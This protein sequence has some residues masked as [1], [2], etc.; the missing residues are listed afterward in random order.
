MQLVLLPGMDGTGELLAPFLAEL[1]ADLKPV[2]VRY[3][4][5]QALG[6]DELEP[7]VD[8]AL[9]DAGP[10]VLLAESYSGPL[11]IRLAARGN[12][13]LVAAVVVGSF[14]RCPVGHWFSW[15]GRLLGPLCVRL[16]P[17][18]WLIRRYLVGDD[19]PAELVAAVRSAVGT[20]APA[21][22]AKRI[23]ETLAVDDRRL[24]P[25]ICVPVLYIA[26]SRDRQIMPSCAEDFQRPGTRFEV[27]SID[28]PHLIL[29]AQPVEAVRLIE[30]FLRS[31]VAVENP[32]S[33]LGEECN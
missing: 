31:V 29:Q 10:Y 33:T 17:P 22:M 32:S 11:A 16:P 15:L 23:R 25:D 3:P 6:Y 5:D 9:P 30:R 21:V 2:V 13:R 14:A 7:L 18:S 28:A 8:S 26:G 20:V 27:A 4:A 19:A 24:L 12:S 1:P